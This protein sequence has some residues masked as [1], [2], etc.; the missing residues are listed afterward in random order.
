[1]PWESVKPPESLCVFQGE[2]REGNTNALGQ[3]LSCVI[4]KKELF[5]KTLNRPDGGFAKAMQY[6]HLCAHPFVCFPAMFQQDSG[7]FLC[8]GYEGDPKYHTHYSEEFL[9][10]D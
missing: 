9:P 3:N 1:M 10:Y 8:S 4:Q 6:K 2:K 7:S 5:K